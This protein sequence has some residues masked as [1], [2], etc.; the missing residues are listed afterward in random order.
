MN[1]K[2]EA[3]SNFPTS[4]PTD[5]RILDLSHTINDAMPQWPGDA[6]SFQARTECTIADDGFLSRSFWMLEHYGT[7]LD[8]P[9]HFAGLG[10]TVDAIPAE[11]L[12]GRAVVL[13]VR[14]LAIGDADY[15][16]DPEV[17]TEW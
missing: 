6:Q 14:E 1:D 3:T 8:A 7:H 15:L 13:D 2:T 9:A 16:L 4:V 5:A 12:F 17:I 11:R 10:M